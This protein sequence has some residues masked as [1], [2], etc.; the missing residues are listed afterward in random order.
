[1]SIDKINT[2]INR[3]NERKKIMKRRRNHALNIGSPQISE[4]DRINKIILHGYKFQ[5]FAVEKKRKIKLET[6]QIKH[7]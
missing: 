7:T 5:A 1:M 6:I 3:S 2:N 4:S